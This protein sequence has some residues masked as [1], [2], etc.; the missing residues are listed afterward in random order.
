MGTKAKHAA[1]QGHLL[2][3][4][5]RKEVDDAKEEVAQAEQARKQE[6]KDKEVAKVK[7]SLR[8][9]LEKKEILEA[10]AQATMQ[11]AEDHDTMQK[12]IAAKERRIREASQKKVEELLSEEWKKK[13]AELK[14]VDVDCKKPHKTELEKLQD[15]IEK[16]QKEKA[17]MALKP[18]PP[19]PSDINPAVKE[20]IERNVRAVTEAEF[21]QKLSTTKKEM[22]QNMEDQIAR[23]KAIMKDEKKKLEAKSDKMKEELIEAKANPLKPS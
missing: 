7:A 4:K 14:L 11:A 8:S 12:V 5:A 17:L 23:E 10:K 21:E 15:N 19:D 22:Q 16:L 20:E 9:V 1:E 2:E 13:K 6:D 3:K 18:T